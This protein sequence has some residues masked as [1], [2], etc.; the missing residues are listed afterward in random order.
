[1][2]FTEIGLAHIA[3]HSPTMVGSLG[4]AGVW[5]G[6]PQRLEFASRLVDRDA[7]G[8]GAVLAGVVGDPTDRPAPGYGSAPGSPSRSSFFWFSGRREGRASIVT[9]T[10]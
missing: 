7:C 9:T 5:T 8:A 10:M 2:Q 4:A 3:L 1:M 6:S